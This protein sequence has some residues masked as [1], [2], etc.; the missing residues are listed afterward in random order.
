MR[1]DDLIRF[2]DGELEQER[3]AAFREHL[4]ACEACRARL[5]QTMQ[6]SARLSELWPP[7]RP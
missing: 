6:L 7:S 4:R 2:T 1:C 5:V 3:A